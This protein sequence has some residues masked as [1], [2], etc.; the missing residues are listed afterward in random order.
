[1]IINYQISTNMETREF[2]FNEQAVNFEISNKNVMVNATQIAKAF[3]KQVND[4]LR[5]DQTNEFL[6]ECLKDEIFYD[7]LGL[8]YESQKDYS[9][10]ENE[11]QNGNNPFENESQNGNSRFENESQTVKSQFENESQE[12]NNPF[13]NESQSGNSRCEIK[14]Q[15]ADLTHEIIE[16]R[17]KSFLKVVKGGQNS[18]TWMHRVLA[19]KF[20][21][22]LSPKFELWIFKTIDDLL[23]GSFREDEET[24]RKIAGIQDKIIEKE[25]EL[26]NLPVLKEIEILRK[27]EQTERRRF[28]QRKKL[29]ISGYRTIF[30][31]NEME[32]G[33][34]KA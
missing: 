3:G 12:E 29:R 4:F 16:E 19:L 28:E 33:N 22:W 11:S 30:T 18:G 10:F 9:P 27:S 6:N 2:N 23:F 7:L 1:M 20:A 34:E 5:L 14:I 15:T 26:K 25:N 8:K 32:G 13:E 31:E 21:A 24:L 17:K